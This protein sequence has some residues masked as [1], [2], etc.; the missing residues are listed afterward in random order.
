[1]EN[2]TNLTNSIQLLASLSSYS[3]V[4]LSTVEDAEIP[5][6][7]RLVKL[8]QRQTKKAQEE[9]RTTEHRATLLPTFSLLDITSSG[10]KAKSL[11]VEL[12]QR[13][14]EL[15]VREL[16]AEGKPLTNE[17]CGLAAT[18]EWATAESKRGGDRLSKEAIKDYYE[19]AVAPVLVESLLA[20]GREDAQVLAA[21][22]AVEA[23]LIKLAVVKPALSKPEATQLL[24]VLALV[25][26]DSTAKA[27]LTAR[28]ELV[29]KAD[30]TN[31]LA[32]LGL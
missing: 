7:F 27:W 16:L 10:E 25:Q 31:L 17:T 2:Q 1:M 29:L 30:D 15:L 32:A 14:Q 23:G 9:G 13:Q 5:A 11:L 18:V 12:M 24:K 22:K 4:Q 26:Q 6:G 3:V 21:G 28:L 20:A 8:Y 19:E